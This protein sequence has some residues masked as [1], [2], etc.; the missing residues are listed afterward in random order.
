ML[1]GT[2]ATK[3]GCKVTT[4]L[5]YYQ[6]FILFLLNKRQKT[7]NFLK[8]NHLNGLASLTKPLVFVWREM[9]REGVEDML[10][11]GVEPVNLLL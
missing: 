6:V 2:G 1:S 9:G 10:M 11:I 3:S 5:E 8:K 4:F 7:A